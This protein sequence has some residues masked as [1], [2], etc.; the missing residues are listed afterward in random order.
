MTDVAQYLTVADAALILGLS[1][2]GVRKAVRTGR[3]NVAATTPSGMRLFSA[4]EVQRFKR[5]RQLSRGG[6]R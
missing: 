5:A 4:S 3:L 1:G 2:D 6:R